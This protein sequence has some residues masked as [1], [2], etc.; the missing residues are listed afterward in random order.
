TNQTL[1]SAGEREVKLTVYRIDPKT[2]IPSGIDVDDAPG[3]ADRQP[4]SLVQSNDEE[5][6]KLA[7]AIPDKETNLPT[8]L[9]AEKLVHETVTEK[10]FSQGFASA[11][12]VARMR[13]G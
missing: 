6:L 2:A 4:S 3:P 11:A 9:A 12:D 1:A 13:E 7:A 10:N 8:A 5:V